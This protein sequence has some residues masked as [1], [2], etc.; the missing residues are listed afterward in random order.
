MHRPEVHAFL[1]VLHS[2]GAMGTAAAALQVS[3]GMPGF[4]LPPGCPKDHWWANLA[5]PRRQAGSYTTFCSICAVLTNHIRIAT[6]LADKIMWT[7]L[8]LEAQWRDRLVVR[9]PMFG[10]LP[11]IGGWSQS[12]GR[13]KL[14]SSSLTGRT[15]QSSGCSRQR[16]CQRRWRASSD[17]E[18]IVLEPGR[19]NISLWWSKT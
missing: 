14:R 18:S 10:G 11:P 3:E 1:Q 9:P 6:S 16:D 4:C 8:H 2:R 12:P 7:R 19:T 13:Y 17:L 5:S 15:K